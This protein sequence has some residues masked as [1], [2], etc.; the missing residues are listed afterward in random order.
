MFAARRE[1]LR[2]VGNAA[3]PAPGDR[4]R[5][6]GGQAANSSRSR[7]TSSWVRLAAARRRAI[8]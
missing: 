1:S 5:S 4:A 7:V 6:A 2:G 3:P 8:G